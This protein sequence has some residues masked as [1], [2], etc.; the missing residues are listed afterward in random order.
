MPSAVAAGAGKTVIFCHLARQLGRRTLVL[1]HRAELVQQTVDR[2]QA[3]W[4]GVQVGVLKQGS[5]QM[6]QQVVVASVQTAMRPK[7]LQQL[8]A[9][10]FELIIVDEAHH[11]PA[12]SYTS[13]LSSLGS[14]EGGTIGSDDD[15]RQER[16][17]ASSRE[18]DGGGCGGGGGSSS[19]GGGGSSGELDTEQASLLQLSSSSASTLLVGFTATP[20]RLDKKSLGEVFQDIVYQRDLRYMVAQGFLVPPVGY[21]IITEEDLSQ[22]RRTKAGDFKERELECLVNTPRRNALAARAYLECAP[23]RR[24]IVFCVGVQALTNCMILTEGYD[25][26]S[27]SCVVMARPTRSTGLYMQ[28]IGRGLRLHAGKQDLVVLDLTDRHHEFAGV[29]SLRRVYSGRTF[30]VAGGDGDGDLPP[31]PGPPTVNLMAALPRG[32]AGRQPAEAQQQQ[33]GQQGEAPFAVAGTGSSSSSGSSG[34]SSSSSSTLRF[35][36]AIIWAEAIIEDGFA[37]QMRGNLASAPWRLKSASD[38]Q[39]W[40]LADM[41]RA[42]RH[43]LSVKEL[44]KLTQGEASGLIGALALLQCHNAGQFEF[45]QYICDG[46]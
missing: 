25:E 34:D 1:V 35:T 32:R 20:F 16:S 24:A 4:P 10:G 43:S 41:L 19:R 36:A 18:G 6:D 2:M 26:T 23:G 42:S 39:L 14:L 12:A 17:S 31:P 40:L 21:R 28:C 38:R 9:Q 33:A 27:V 7:T 8:A 29:A 37:W 11:A 13:I 15:S 45:E 22:A 30:A 5:R 3:V 46:A 44:G